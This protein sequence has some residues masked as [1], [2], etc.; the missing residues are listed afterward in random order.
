MTP[1]AERRRNTGVLIRHRFTAESL[2]HGVT[3]GIIVIDVA[4]FVFETIKVDFVFAE[5]ERR[6][7]DVAVFDHFAVGGN[8]ILVNDFEFVAFFN[9]AAEIDA[10]G[11]NV[12]EVGNDAGGHFFAVHGA[13]QAA[14]DGAAGRVDFFNQFVLLQFGDVLSFF[15]FLNNEMFAAANLGGNAVNGDQFV[16]RQVPFHADLQFLPGFQIAGIV[17]FFGGQENF[18]GFSVFQ[19][20]IRQNVEQGVALFDGN[21]VFPGFFRRF[22]FDGLFR[23]GEFFGDEIVV[24]LAEFF[25]VDFVFDRFEAGKR[26]RKGGVDVGVAQDDDH[27]A[28]GDDESG[29][30]SEPAPFVFDRCRKLFRNIFVQNQKSFIISVI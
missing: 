20:E 8:V 11:K 10:V 26:G 23:R 21:G 24:G 15:V 22:R 14:V 29:A 27:A 5:R 12:D 3:L 4:A 2:F 19:S 25:V 30:E 18:V 6:K 16:F 13:G 9:V 28:Q 17:D 7:Q 1:A